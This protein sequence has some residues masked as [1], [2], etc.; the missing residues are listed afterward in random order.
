MGIK[1]SSVN[2]ALDTS[3]VWS[4]ASQTC[5]GCP[6]LFLLGHIISSLALTLIK[7]TSWTASQCLQDYYKVAGQ[8]VGEAWRKVDLRN[9]NLTGPGTRIIMWLDWKTNY[10][11]AR[12]LK[13][14][15]LK[16]YSTTSSFLMQ[17]V[18]SFMNL[19]IPT[20]KFPIYTTF[21][22]NFSLMEK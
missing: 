5:P 18:F 6:I 3:D 13:K 22:F 21:M 15:L 20:A 14:W 17:F 12:E 1:T 19:K 10:V 16:N 11:G 8:C 9:Q 4:S 7:L 2:T